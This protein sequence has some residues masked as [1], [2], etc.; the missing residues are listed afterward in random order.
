MDME[1]EEFNKIYLGLGKLNEQKNVVHILGH[2]SVADSLDWTQKGAVTP[3][4]NQG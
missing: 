4:K 1:N 3:V 2:E